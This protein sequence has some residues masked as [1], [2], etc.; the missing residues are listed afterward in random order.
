MSERADW[1]GGKAWDQEGVSPVLATILTV[2]IAVVL[3]ASVYLITIGLTKGNHTAPPP[4]GVTQNDDRDTLNVVYA[5]ADNAQ[6]PQWSELTAIVDGDPSCQ[7]HDTTG[8]IVPSGSALAGG[9]VTPGQGLT[10]SGNPGA[11]CNLV[12]TYAP[13]DMALGEWTFHT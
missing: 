11:I 3:A 13:G 10:V 12:L 5:P 6:T 4:L 7:I 2:A 8:N 9:R 1:R